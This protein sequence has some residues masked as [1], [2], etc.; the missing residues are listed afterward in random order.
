MLNER[1]MLTIR[2]KRVTL[3]YIRTCVYYYIG[4]P[5]RP[6]SQTDVKSKPEFQRVNLAVAG[7]TLSVRYHT[8]WVSPTT[9]GYLLK[10][11]VLMR[12]MISH[13]LKHVKF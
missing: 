6:R 12:L 5:P 4:V 10:Y 13:S 1:K 9:V 3:E 7:Y 11:L 2:R 8:G